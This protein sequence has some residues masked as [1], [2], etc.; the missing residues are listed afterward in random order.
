MKSYNKRQHHVLNNNC[1]AALNCFAARRQS[2]HFENNKKRTQQENEN[3]TH[4]P[5]TYER[6]QFKFMYNIMYTNKYVIIYSNG[7]CA[8]RILFSLTSINDVHCV[9]DRIELAHISLNR[10]YLGHI[11]IQEFMLFIDQ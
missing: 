9:V 4:T 1:A 10:T 2:I 11:A 7:A 3:H 5:H 8:G 6:H